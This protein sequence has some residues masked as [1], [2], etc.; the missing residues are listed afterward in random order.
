MKQTFSRTSNQPVVDPTLKIYGGNKRRPT[1]RVRLKDT[2]KIV[3]IDA[4]AFDPG[5]HEQLVS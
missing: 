1:L 3:T 4:A 5:V 2:D